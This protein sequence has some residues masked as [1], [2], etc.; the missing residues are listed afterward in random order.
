MERNKNVGQAMPDNASQEAC[1]LMLLTTKSVK[2][3]QAEPDLRRKQRGGF[4]LIELLVVVLIIGILAAVALPQ[5]QKAVWKSRNAQLKTLVSSV[6]KAQQAYRMSNGNFTNRFDELSI[7][8]PLTV[9]DGSKC[10]M[11]AHDDL[12]RKG[13]NFEVQLR[14]NPPIMAWWT[15]G[16]YKCAGFAYT[17]DGAMWCVE[18]AVYF[19]GTSGSF[20]KKIEK[21]KLDTATTVKYNS[22]A[23]Y[24]YTLPN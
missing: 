21:A 2:P 19:T 20:C 15:D 13:D 18:R 8:L 10:G 1:I 7:D 9:S 14:V 3:C 12:G 4:T 23:S 17:E 24:F 16:P 22:V 6:G 11:V 5:Y